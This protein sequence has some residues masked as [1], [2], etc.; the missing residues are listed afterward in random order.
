MPQCVAAFDRLTGLAFQQLQA[1]LASGIVLVVYYALRRRSVYQL[2]EQRVD[3]DRACASGAFAAASSRSTP[4][5]DC[6]VRLWRASW[7]NPIGATDPM[8][9]VSCVG[10]VMALCVAAK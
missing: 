7:D 3:D 5:S 4:G 9:V 6:S 10:C 2:E 8:N 1:S